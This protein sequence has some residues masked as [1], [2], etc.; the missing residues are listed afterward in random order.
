MGLHLRYAEIFGK[1]LSV[2]SMCLSK[3][4]EEIEAI[5]RKWA[6]VISDKYVRQQ[7]EE[8]ARIAL[9]HGI[10]DLPELREA[11]L[12]K[13]SKYHGARASFQAG[14]TDELPSIIRVNKRGYRGWKEAHANAVRYGQL[15]Q[16]N[17]LLHELGHYIDYCN[18]SA[19]YRKL[20]HTWKVENVDE[21]LV[22]KHL[23]TYALSDY[24][25]FEAELN[26]AIMRG[27]VLPKEL[28]SYSHMNQVDTPLAKRMLSLASG[29]SVCLPNEEVC[30]GFKDAMKVLFH[31]K[32]SSFSIDI[33][34]DKNVQ[35]L[36]EAHTSV[37]DRNLQRLEMS[38]LMR[39]RLTRSNYIFSGIKTFHELNEAFPSLLDS[40]GNRKTF[41]AFLNDVRKIDKTY[42]SNYLRA[43]YNFVQSSAEMAAKWERFSE[44][45][46]RYNLQYRTA[47]DSK[48][49]PEHAA[50]NGLTLPPSDPFWEEYYPPNGW[51]CR[52]TVVQVRKSKHPATPHE[53]AMALGVEALQ[54]DTKGTFHFNP[55]KQNKTVPDYNPYTIRR[56]R[57]CD[58]AKG[59]IKLARFVPENELCSA[60]KLIHSCW[61]KVKEETPETFT[62]CETSNGKLRVSSKHGKTEKKEN[63]RVGRYLAE[64]HGYEIDLIANPQNE[65][66]ADSFNKTL[67]I[68]QEYKVN[69]TPTGNSIDNLIRKGAKQAHDLVLFVDS[70]ISLDELSNA[71]NNRVRR[72]NLKT[73]MVVINGM[74][75]TYTYDEITA[76]GFK[77]R[78]ADLK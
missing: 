17:P 26:A 9:R 1:E 71:L 13:I 22:K 2:S 45:G 11:D 77:I 43:E 15:V 38:D 54:R 49:R 29:D 31:Q 40:N 48:V 36:I 27:K 50:L 67:G 72:T 24:A 57:D 59:K 3:N 76:N 18:D 44:D 8:A 19:N 62:E 39:Q 68:E 37:L 56:C 46:D 12:G 73:V 34:A 41:E 28:L 5:A 10:K 14:M 25:E 52:C 42:N 53:E 35:G 63:V 75:K 33:L 60:C 69:A 21:A 51:N 23:S 6:S 20:E 47:N 7:A 30:K 74:D 58:I 55:G 65:T 4:E 70:G 61:A 16:D 64:K 66:S 32:G 78:Q